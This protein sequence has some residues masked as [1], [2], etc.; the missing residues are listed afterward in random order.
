MV[1]HSP[2]MTKTLELVHPRGTL[3]VPVRTL[4][5][6]CNLFADNPMLAGP[7][8]SVRAPVSMEDFRQFVSALKDKDVEVTNRNFGG[9]SLLCDEFRFTALSERLSAFRKS[10]DFKEV[11]TA[12]VRQSQTAASLAVLPPLDRPFRFMAKGVTLEC[13]VSEAASV[14]AAVREQFSVDAC[15]CTFFLSDVGVLSSLRCIISGS[16]VS[17]QRSLSTLGRQ[18]CNPMLELQSVCSETHRFDLNSIDLSSL[19]VDSVDQIL[20]EGL[21][22]IESEDDLF[23]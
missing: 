8:Y 6:K 16:A 2:K 19:S 4:V 20:T 18:L 12:E 5:M 15:A 1:N 13:D 10:A 23:L 7:P 14:S 11:A 22:Y 3:K 9:L 21:F 17:D